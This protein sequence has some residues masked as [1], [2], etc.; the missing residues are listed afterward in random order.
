[1]TPPDMPANAFA[2][3][4]STPAPVGTPAPTAASAAPA[5]GSSYVPAIRKCLDE[6]SRATR[7][8]IAAAI[9]AG[10]L[11]ALAKNEKTP[12][13]KRV[14]KQGTWIDWLEKNFKLS[15]RTARRY[16][17]LADNEP[18]VLA[19]MNSADKMATVAVS[20][21]REAEAA[22]IAKKPETEEQ[23]KKR[24]QRQAEAEAKKVAAKSNSAPASN[25]SPI[26]AK[27][28]A[29]NAD[30]ADPKAVK[31]LTEQSM[32]ALSNLKRNRPDDAK[33]IVTDMIKRLQ[34]LLNA[35][36]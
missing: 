9:E 10:K 5:P 6:I 25:H 20:T 19:A 8:S 23:R 1:M 26:V 27:V 4:T 13:G 29:G 21:I 14:I 12:D 33:A 11:L 7:T 18:A 34:G 16:M 15:D 17:H 2:P 3:S 35:P 22:L 28:M 30:V 31:V 24:E 36:D 32:T